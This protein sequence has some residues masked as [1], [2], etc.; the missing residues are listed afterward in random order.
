MFEYNDNLDIKKEIFHDSI[1]YTID[2][3][4][5]NPDIICDYLFGTPPPFHKIYEFPSYNNVYFQDRRL[6]KE[7]IRLKPV[8]DFLSELVSQKPDSYDIH[9]NQYRFYNHEFNDYKNCVWWPHKDPGYNA[10][11]YF[12]KDDSECGTNL[13]LPSTRETKELSLR[14]IRFFKDIPINTVE[15]AAPWVKKE[16][17][18]I[19]K[20]FEPKYNRLVIFDGYKFLHGMNIVNDRYFSEEYRKNQLFLFN[21]F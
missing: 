1:I 18:E 5:K 8:V 7:D 6:I 3:F 2:N 15:H 19:I 11:V 21:K 4:Y 10:I 17:Y 12:N 9:T 16:K 14:G 13:Y 20:T